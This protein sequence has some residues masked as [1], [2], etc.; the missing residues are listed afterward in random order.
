MCTRIML[1]QPAL[2]ALQ[3]LQWPEV[4]SKG[5]LAESFAALEQ[6]VYESRAVTVHAW[7]LSPKV[8]DANDPT[9][10]RQK[11]ARIGLPQGIQPGPRPRT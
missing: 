5:T 11:K 3:E 1:S 2:Y 8:M 4:T 7:L 9:L 6:P 10:H